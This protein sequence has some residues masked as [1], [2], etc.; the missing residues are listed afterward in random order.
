MSIKPI[1]SL[2]DRIIL[3]KKASY[4]VSYFSDQ[5][6]SKLSQTDTVILDFW[7]K[8]CDS[9]WKNLQKLRVELDFCGTVIIVSF[10]PKEL[11][12]KQKHSEI[13]KT[14][15]CF[16]LQMP[17]L[18]G[19]LFQL[20]ENKVT[21]SDE[22]M[23]YIKRKIGAYYAFHSSSTLIHD[24]DNKFCLALAH[25]YQL[26]KFSS[27]KTFS[28]F[29]L[30]QAVDAFNKIKMYLTREKLQGFHKEFPNLHEEINKWNGVEI[31]NIQ[32][33]QQYWAVIDAWVSFS[34]SL[35]SDK[36]ELHLSNMF[37]QVKPVQTAIGEISA[38]LAKVQK[39]AKEVLG[40]AN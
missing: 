5:L 27:Y 17:F 39:Q 23:L 12:L 40:Y 11:L 35:N 30:K 10:V 34:D 4:S 13:I 1:Q 7:G 32:A 33:L 9:L 6:S 36:I 2:I 37:K 26:E 31:F 29:E 3:S 28:E 8:D 14:L 19:D 20:L 22:E 16:Y 24:Y 25:L 21:L 15:G 18:I 38:V